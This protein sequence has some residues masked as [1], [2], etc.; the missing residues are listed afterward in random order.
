LNQWLADGLLLYR[1]FII[2]AMSYWVIAIPSLMY[3]ASVALGITAAYQSSQPDSIVR[4]SQVVDFGSPYYFIS[5]SLNLLLTFMIV[6]RLVL[7]SRVI[8]N[9]MGPLVKPDRLYR[10][11]VTILVESSALYAVSFVLF[12]G[13]WRAVNA[14]QY[15]FLPIL[16]EVQV[17]APFLITL[18]VANRTALTEHTIVS[19]DLG[20]IH[21]VSQGDS[22]SG[23]RS[24][25]DENPTNLK[26]GRG[27][28]PSGELDVGAKNVIEEVTL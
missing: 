4:N 27:E 6:I 3:L 2:Y 26:D 5:L 18:R 12:I 25:H 15:I 14:A 16:S 28:T 19:G 22:E 13:P 9:A 24:V 11:I 21:F 23:D 10:T 8:R 20:S 17:I 1:C 7:H